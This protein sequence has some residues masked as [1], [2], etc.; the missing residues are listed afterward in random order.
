M[1]TRLERP[2]LPGLL[3]LGQAEALG[4]TDLAAALYLD[5]AING[6]ENER[7]EHVVAD[8][9][10]DVSPLEI[11]LMRMHSAN[12]TFSILGDLRQS[13][14]SYKSISNWNQPASLFERE[15]VSRT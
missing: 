1:W 6:F 13:V 3:L 4:M 7:F 5:Y 15:S 2:K 11:T 10:Q 12:D 9:A 8:E 14:L